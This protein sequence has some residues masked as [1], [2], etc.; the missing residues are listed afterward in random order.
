[1]VSAKELTSAHNAVVMA[2]GGDGFF[3]FFQVYPGVKIED[4]GGS[5]MAL[6]DV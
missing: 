1:M 2:G 4:W 6:V 3:F 5:Q